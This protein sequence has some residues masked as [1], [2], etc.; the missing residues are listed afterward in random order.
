MNPKVYNICVESKL[1]TEALH[2][3]QMQNELEMQNEHEHD[4]SMESG[5]SE[6]DQNSSDDDEFFDPEEEESAIEQSPEK[7]RGSHAIEKMLKLQAA[8]MT[9]SHNRIG[10]RCPVPD[11]MPLIESGDQVCRC[12]FNC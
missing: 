12:C 4:E 8:V 11:T 7:K 3:K 2:Q 10:A 5:G 1:S 9:S 6:L